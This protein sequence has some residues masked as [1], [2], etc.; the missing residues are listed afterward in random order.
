MGILDMFRG[1]RRADA[2][3]AAEEVTEEHCPHTALAPHWDEP[4][5]MGQDDKATYKCESCGA[6]FNYEEARHF[7]DEPPPALLNAQSESE[8]ADAAEGR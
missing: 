5:E 6:T 1:G 2:G 7:L 4:E 3:A 8:A